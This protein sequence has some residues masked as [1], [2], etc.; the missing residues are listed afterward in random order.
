M[1]Q[2]QYYSPLPRTG[3][4]A[5]WSSS[6]RLYRC[7]RLPAGHLR[8]I[9]PSQRRE[10]G[11]WS[12]VSLHRTALGGSSRQRRRQ[13]ALSGSAGGRLPAPAARS[14]RPVA[15]LPGPS[16]RAG[17]QPGSSDAAFCA[18]SDSR[19][20]LVLFVD[21][22]SDVLHKRRKNAQQSGAV[23][24]YGPG[25]VVRREGRSGSGA[26]VTARGATFRLCGHDCR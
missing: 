19:Q 5:R 3:R 26:T 6:A 7:R 13:T 24:S 25:C 2:I 1:K 11:H 8:T 23:A 4:F 20:F 14:A 21:M 15:Q 18:T 22:Y 12:T 10:T 16:K 17:R 9:H